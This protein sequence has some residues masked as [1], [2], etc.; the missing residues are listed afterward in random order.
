MTAYFSKLL[1]LPDNYKY[2][3]AA[4]SVVILVASGFLFVSDIEEIEE[5]YI[6]IPFLY[7]LIL[8]GSMW[9]ILISFLLLSAYYPSLENN[10]LSD[11][12][13]DGLELVVIATFATIMTYFQ[14]NSLDKMRLFR[15]ESYTDYLTRL[16]NR[17]KIMKHM[18]A[19]QKKISLLRSLSST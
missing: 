1:R 9:P 17:K 12:I 15:N 13:E 11:V 14:Q 7:L 5:M 2:Y 10:E 19:L 4:I 6:F 18:F 16:P 8:P 3:A